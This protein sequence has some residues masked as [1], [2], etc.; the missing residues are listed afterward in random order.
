MT[1]LAANAT[2]GYLG[3]FMFLTFFALVIF[4][5]VRPGAKAEADRNALI[6]FKE[7]KPNG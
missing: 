3:L 5:L 7:E 4:T 6:P 1:P 2:A